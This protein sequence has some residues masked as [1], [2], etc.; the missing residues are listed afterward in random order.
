MH[1]DL[2]E[3]LY[4]FFQISAVGG[5][6]YILATGVFLRYK[7]KEMLDNLTTL[8]KTCKL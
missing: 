6:I 7:I 8:Y 5:V 3:S 2:E 4:A 1:T